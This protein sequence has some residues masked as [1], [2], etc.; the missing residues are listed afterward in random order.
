MSAENTLLVC[1]SNRSIEERTRE[2]IVQLTRLGMPFLHQKGSAD[3]AYARNLALSGACELLDQRP[4]ISVVLMVDDDMTFT[5]DQALELVKHARDTG[6]P[7]S[8]VYGTLNGIIA[9]TRYQGRQSHGRALWLVGLG[10]VAISREK[11]LDLR[12]SS[13]RYQANSQSKIEHAYQFTWTGVDPE[14]HEWVAEDFRLCA[15]L[16]GVHLLP[17]PLGHVKRVEIFPDEATLDQVRE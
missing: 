1:S 17:V 16:G 13:V 11:L 3:V 7:A 10:L 14:N 4:D 12:N 6:V 2:C 15:R 8:G 5:T 9:A